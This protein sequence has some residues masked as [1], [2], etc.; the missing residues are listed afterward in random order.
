MDRIDEV[1]AAVKRDAER[2]KRLTN[3]LTSVIVVFL[4]SVP[5]SGVFLSFWLLTEII[6]NIL[7][8]IR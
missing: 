5:V 8:W 3:F 2:N 7:G 4:V 6:N 1:L